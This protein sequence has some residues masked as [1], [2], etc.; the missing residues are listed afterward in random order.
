MNRENKRKQLYYRRANVIG[1]SNTLQR[2]LEDALFTERRKVKDRI[3]EVSDARDPDSHYHMFINT[4]V[5]DWGMLFGSVILHKPDSSKQAIVVDDNTDQF[6]VEALAPFSGKDGK[7]R[8]FFDSIAYFGVLDNHV[9]IVQ[10]RTIRTK[11]VEGYF[12]WLLHDCDK[13]T[14]VQGVLLE[15]KFSF[16]TRDKIRRANVKKVKASLPLLSGLKAKWDKNH[17]T[18]RLELSGTGLDLLRE[19]VG[20]GRYDNLNIQTEDLDDLEVNIEVKYNR[21]ASDGAQELLNRLT[22]AVQD[23][24]DDDVSVELKGTGTVKGDEIEIKGY[25]SITH[26]NDHVEP[27]DLFSQMFEWLMANLESGTVDP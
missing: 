3:L 1:N 4:R 10:T 15:S 22:G 9:I 17:T 21:K 7:R 20:R 24:L 26:I 2:L 25:R 13:L 11:E 14:D 18:K 27:S 12:E 6:D 16:E 8:Q 23:S 19:L 5:N